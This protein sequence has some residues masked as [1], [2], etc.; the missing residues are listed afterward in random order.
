[1]SSYGAN[2]PS[3]A[4]ATAAQAQSREGAVDS[5][6]PPDSVSFLDSSAGLYTAGLYTLDEHVS[7]A[8]LLPPYERKSSDPVY[9]PLKIFTLDPT[10]SFLVGSIALIN[11]PYEPLKP[12]PEGHL[13]RVESPGRV[14]NLE[15]SGVLI[16]NGITPSMSDSLF[17]SQM[18]YA[19]CSS[20]Y[21]AFRA[22]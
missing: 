5:E 19:V 1:M 10:T 14:L 4:E 2:T 15:D 3:T 18:T 12:G 8:D 13:L 20:V 6:K 22:E 21:A 17:R 7:R 16:R 11:L 9:R